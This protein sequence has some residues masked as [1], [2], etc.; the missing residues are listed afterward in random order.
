MHRTVA[1][2]MLIAGSLALPI[3]AQQPPQAP[4]T[5]V[6]FLR[7]LYNGNKNNIL[8]SADKMPEED[9]ENADVEQVRAPHQL[10][11][12]QQLAGAGPPRVLLAVEAQQAAEEKHRQ[13]QVG[14]PAEDDMIDGVAHG[15]LLR[16][17]WTACR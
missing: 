8:R 5:A 10:T 11:P 6:G 15:S 3:A 4:P 13:A 2:T 7:N 9:D 16:R 17:G 12:A 1:V 14:I